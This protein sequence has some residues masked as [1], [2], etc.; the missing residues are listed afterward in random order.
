MTPEIAEMV[1]STTLLPKTLEDSAAVSRYVAQRVRV[2]TDH[3]RSQPAFCAGVRMD[4]VPPTQRAHAVA[5]A[6]AQRCASELREWGKC[7][8]CAFKQSYCICKRLARLA[9]ETSGLGIASR[10]RFIVLMHVYERQRA[11][12]TGKLVE[13]LLPGSEVLFHNVEWD[14]ARLRSLIAAAEGRAFAVFPSPNAVSFAEFFL[15]NASIESETGR[16]PPTVAPGLIRE[17]ATTNGIPQPLLAVLVDGTW[18]QAKRMWRHLPDLPHVVL[19]PR[20]HSE[21]HWRRQSAE[22]RIST[23]EAAAL[24]L[25]DLGE[26]LGGAPTILR[27]GLAVLNRALERQTHYDMMFGGKP[28]PTPSAQKIAALSLRLPKRGPGQRGF[29]NFVANEL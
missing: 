29:S 20:G 10:L 21:F 17:R 13:V 15:G 2:D 6:R 22:G 8:K 14:V 4:I 9:G 26:P 25:E 5:A 23:V 11:S 19:S 12:N 3:K 16:L 18:G 1:P 27:N 7:D 24:L 28:V